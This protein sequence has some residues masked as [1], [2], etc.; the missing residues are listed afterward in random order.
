[1]HRGP[2]DLQKLGQKHRSHSWAGY[3]SHQ[4]MKI[5]ISSSCHPCKCVY[6]H[7]LSVLLFSQCCLPPDTSK[8]S[9]SKSLLLFNC[10]SE[11]F[12]FKKYPQLTSYRVTISFHRHCLIL[13]GS[14]RRVAPGRRHWAAPVP[15]TP[16]VS[17]TQII[18]SYVY[19]AL[20]QKYF[21]LCGDLQF[22]VY[23]HKTQGLRKVHV[24]IKGAHCVHPVLHHSCKCRQKSLKA[25]SFPKIHAE[26]WKVYPASLKQR[27]LE[28]SWVV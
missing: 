13:R 14:C 18:S 28:H 8:I 5:L 21:R 17:R 12:S 7:R 10:S 11:P 3:P 19:V 24:R 23:K 26:R 16:T 2:V 9:C 25:K 20:Q 15:V 4:V 22:V 27:R 6:F 1:M